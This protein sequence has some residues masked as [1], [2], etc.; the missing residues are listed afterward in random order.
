[1]SSVKS[2]IKAASIT[3]LAL[4]PV[5]VT[6]YSADGQDLGVGGGQ[7]TLATE[8][9]MRGGVFS[10]WPVVET[11]P[12]AIELKSPTVS[13]LSARFAWSEMEPQPGAYQWAALDAAHDLTLAAKK[14]LMVRVTAGMRSPSWVYDRG[15]RKITFPAEDTNFLKPGTQSTMPVPWD[16]AYLAAW[17]QFLQALGQH[18]RNWTNLYCMQMTGGGFIGEMHLPKQSAGVVAQWEAVGI[19]D[20]KLIAMWQRIIR[21]YDKTMPQGVGLAL[22]LGQPFKRSQATPAI[23]AWALEK[24]PGRVWFQQNGLNERVR[25]E[26][27]YAQMLQRAART[28]TVGYQMLGGGKFLDRQTGDRRKCFERAIGDG[29]RY[30]EVYRPDLLDPKWQ[31]ALD[32]L[33]NELQ[34]TAPPISSK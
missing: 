14:W 33:A 7:A 8:K 12:Q 24:Y 2:A 17:E 22:D 1:M 10:L 34:R 16:E 11:F 27:E 28:T 30:V 32:Y 13:G 4:L 18:V 23:F 26:G 19:S 20:E 6:D 15:C 29:C 5:F 31:S 25:A 21:A 9:P 3:L